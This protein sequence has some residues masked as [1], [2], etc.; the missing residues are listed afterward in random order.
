MYSKIK[1]ADLAQ[2]RK[3]SVVTRPFSPDPTISREKR[4][5]EPSRISWSLCTLLRQCHL[6]LFKTLTPNPL[7]KGSDTWVKFYC[8]KRSLRNNYQ[9]CNL[10]GHYHFW[11]RSPRNLTLF[12]RPLLAG[13]HARAWDYM[14]I[15]SS[16]GLTKHVL[17]RCAGF[18]TGFSVGEGN[19]MVA[20][21]W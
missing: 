9:S 10:I 1:I 21:W 16:H 11:G 19:R 8:C 13:R 15:K 12:T 14:C 6:A 20:G 18:H 4:S 3:R 7:K 17:Y 5:C 2:A